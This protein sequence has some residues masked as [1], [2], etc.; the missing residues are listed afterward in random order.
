MTHVQQRSLQEVL[1]VWSSVEAHMK[2][3]KSSVLTF[4]LQVNQCERLRVN[5][6]RPVLR[7]YCHL[8]EKINF[9]PCT[10][11]HMHIHS[12][13]TMLNQC[14]LA[15]RRSAARLLL[16][17]HEEALQ[18]EALLRLQ[19]EESVSQW[20]R[21]QAGH[22]LQEFRLSVASVDVWRLLSEQ[23]TFHEADQNLRQLSQRRCDIVKGL[24]SLAPP[25]LSA[26]LVSDW[27]AQ[28]TAVNQQ[29]DTCHADFLH[30]LRCHYEL[31]WQDR[32]SQV[33]RCQVR[34]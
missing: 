5:K 15:N 8:L 29:I 32:V 1:C 31:M 16:L 7:R 6:I 17:L 13:A 23:Q 10:N 24:G 3:K 9:L 34:G 4:E 21:S 2:E 26:A 12:Q 14:L 25:S 33:K 19:W 18:Q 22:M 27:L 20:R 11:T 30:Q 28:L